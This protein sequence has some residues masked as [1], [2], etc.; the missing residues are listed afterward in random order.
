MEENA[1]TGSKVLANASC[2]RLAHKMEYRYF[3]SDLIQ[4]CHQKETPVLGETV[5]NGTIYVTIETMVDIREYNDRGGHN[6]FR[7][8]TTG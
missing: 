8:C 1:R 6:P 3:L 5:D 2:A 7:A 4:T